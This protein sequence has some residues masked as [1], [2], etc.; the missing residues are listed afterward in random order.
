MN[1]VDV[2][3]FGFPYFSLECSYRFVPNDRNWEVETDGFLLIN[4]TDFIT[5]HNYLFVNTY[6]TY[7]TL[8]YVN[9]NH[10]IIK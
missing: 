8:H 2:T 5:L 9:K 6:N 4:E 3:F 10:Q 7:I 1:I